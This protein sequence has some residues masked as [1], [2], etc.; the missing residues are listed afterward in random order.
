MGAS[1]CCGMHLSPAL[2]PFPLELPWHPHCSQ[3]ELC[4]ILQLIPS[5]TFSQVYFHFATPFHQDEA[6]PLPGVCCHFWVH[7]LDPPRW[8]SCCEC[9][10]ASAMKHTGQLWLLGQSLLQCMP[11]TPLLAWAEPPWTRLRQLLPS[12]PGSRQAS[13]TL[14]Q[15]CTGFQIY[16]PWGLSWPWCLP[17][18]PSRSNLQR[19]SHLCPWN[20][21]KF[22]IHRH[23]CVLSSVAVVFWPSAVTASF[24]LS[25]PDIFLWPGIG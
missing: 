5:G 23:V 6:H 1:P 18:T 11:W 14:P 24:D 20:H 17:V 22:C 8:Q 16:L 7:Y 10:G 19:L 3:A 21:D 13:I 2:G 4:Q 12:F 25:S 9:C 15:H